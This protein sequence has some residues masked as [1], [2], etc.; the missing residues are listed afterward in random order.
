[1]AYDAETQALADEIKSEV[2]STYEKV[3]KKTE[4]LAQ[5]IDEIRKAV[6][7]KA[8][9][10][11]LEGRLKDLQVEVKKAVD[12]ADEVD[13]KASRPRGSDIEGKSAGQIAS[14]SEQFK[15]MQQARRGSTGR[16]EMKAITLANTSVSGQTVQALGQAQRVGL[17]GLPQQP[18]T[19]RSLLAQGRTSQSAVEYPRMTGFTNAAAPVAELALKPESNMQFSMETVPVRTIAHWVAASKQVLDDTPMLESIIDGQLR[20][21][22]AV[23]ED[24]QLLLGDGTGQNLEGIIP[25]ATA[26][27]A[28][29]I[30][31]GSTSFVD[32]LRWAKLQARKAFLPADG[33]VLNPEDWAKIEL[34]KDADGRYLYSAF[35]SG[36]EQRLWGLRVVESDA[37]A[38][39]SFLVGAFATAAQIWDRED[40]GVEVSTEDKDNFVR[41]AI[42]VRAEERLALTV[43]RPPA[44][45]TGALAAA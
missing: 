17:V 40:A 11:D 43:Y 7:G 18:V 45:I 32:R 19:V 8:D 26:F 23:I 30:P 12:L 34:L 36:A 27:S 10:T 6:E 33:V 31:A 13:K 24:A 15:A 37:I 39:G 1:M 38:A 28:T 44:F 29:G 20:Y 25:Q 42:T 4:D 35:T 3:D 2:K 14:A 41:N 21:G 9:T 22:L 5:V 16:I